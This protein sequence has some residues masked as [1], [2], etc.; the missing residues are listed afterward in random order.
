MIAVIT[1]DIINSQHADTEVWITK[2]KNLLDKWG[3]A[4]ETWEIY[5]G[6]EFQFKCNI[7]D[8][9][10]HFLA[11]KSL[12]KSQENLDV[13]IAIGIGEESFSSEKI[14]ESNG[15]AY[16]NSGR[17]LN[18]LK[19]DGDTVSIKTSNDPIDRDLNILLKWAS[20]D[21]D[22]WTMATAEIIHEMIM[23]QDYTQEDLAKKFTI[24]QSSISQRLKRANY[25]LIVETNHYF[26]KKIS[27]L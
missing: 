17:L 10:W 24:S 26:K 27:E 13:R 9:F 18:D 19:S 11:I 12:I 20:K 23:N 21:F 15:S 7:D 14:T 25:E 8:V 2:L 5:R 22:N 1:G 4:P 6:D 16:V 3:S